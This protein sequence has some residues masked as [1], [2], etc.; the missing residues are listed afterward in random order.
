MCS[1]VYAGRAQK[2]VDDE[3]DVAAENIPNVDDVKKDMLALVDKL[4][5]NLKKI[6]GGEASASAF[7]SRLCP[8]RRCFAEAVSRT[9]YGPL[10]TAVAVV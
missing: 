1:A 3:A 10:S 7:P 6:R 8:R 9:A 4:K 2:P 5:N